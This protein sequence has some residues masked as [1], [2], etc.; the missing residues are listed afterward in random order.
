ML[1]F[2][3]M[4]EALVAGN[5]TTVSDLA[6]AALDDGISAKEILEKGLM[7]G[8]DIVGDSRGLEIREDH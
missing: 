4:I 2:Q 7:A 1:D 3:N 8:M 6:L 5:E